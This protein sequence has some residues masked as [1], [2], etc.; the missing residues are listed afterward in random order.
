MIFLIENGNSRFKEH[1]RLLL[2]SNSGGGVICGTA[3]FYY[4]LLCRYVLC[5]KT[6]ATMENAMQS[7]KL[8]LWREM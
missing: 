1:K 8:Y 5:I 2:Y 3:I 4:R 6:D 7:C